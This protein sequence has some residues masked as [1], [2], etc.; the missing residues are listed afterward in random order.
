MRKWWSVI[1]RSVALAALSM[2]GGPAH[3]QS[4][5]AGFEVVEFDV[6]G[7]RSATLKAYLRRPPATADATRVRAPAVIALHGCGG[8]FGPTGKFSARELAWAGIWVADGYAVLFPDSFNPR[9]YREICGLSESGRPI[10]PRHRAI[11]AA[12]ALGWLAAQPFVDATRIALVGWSHGGSSTLWAAQ[13]TGADTSSRGFKSA[14]AFYPGCRPA[15]ES[16]DYAPGLPLTI[17]IGSADD[18]TPAAPCRDLA[19]RHPIRLIEYPAAVHGFD[20]PNSPRRT[21]SGVG[22]SGNGR[23]SVQV[24][25]DLVARAAAIAEVR[26]ILGEAFAVPSPP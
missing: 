1:A 26:Q 14:I 11:D 8:L 18:W 13:K 6:G 20:A 3:S 25:T 19:A 2:A 15:A 23:G 5:P 22:M 4:P 9:G 24:G 12:A 10:R 7:Q 21:R 16:A 17:L